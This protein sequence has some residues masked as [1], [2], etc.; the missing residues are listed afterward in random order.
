MKS[1]REARSPLASSLGHTG[2]WIRDFPAPANLMSYIRHH[3][4]EPWTGA[5]RL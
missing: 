3:F 2:V 5:L 1:G 4:A